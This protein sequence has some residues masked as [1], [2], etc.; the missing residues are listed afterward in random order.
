MKIYDRLATLL[1]INSFTSDFLSAFATQDGQNHL[2]KLTEK[3]NEKLQNAT[4]G[5]LAKW[6]SSIETIKRLVD[7]AYL[8]QQK[9]KFD[10]KA[11]TI[12]GNL[13]KEMPELSKAIKDELMTLHP[14]RKGP[15]ELFGVFIDTEWR[16][17]L[18]WDR[19]KKGLSS[20]NGNSL[21]G[22]RVLDVGCGNGYHLWRMY[23]EGAHFCLG[24]DP[25][26]LFLC[27]FFCI[28]QFVGNAAIHL[29]PFAFEEIYEELAGFDVVFSMGVLPHRRDPLEHI[30]MLKQC[31]TSGGELVLESLVIE[32]EGLLKP[33]GRYAKM[34][35]VW[36]IP[37]VSLIEEWLKHEGFS[38]IRHIDTTITTTEEQRTTEWMRFESLKDFLDPTDPS[39][40]IEGHPAPRRAI[41]IARN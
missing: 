5:D 10:A 28:K 40:T 18:K 3:L 31:L 2:S 23:G 38:D 35:N 20:F 22:K 1:N 6:L 16:S 11:M 12:S 21:N 17:D 9:I 24:I 4:H 36:Q 15:Y 27:Q 7:N 32:G 34:R 41:I 26:W 37:S 19:V 13:I 8:Q 30:R 33:D 29:L 39:K 14:W 25:M